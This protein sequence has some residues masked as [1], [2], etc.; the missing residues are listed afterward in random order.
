MTTNKA[1]PTILYED[2]HILVAVKPA[3]VLSQE[4]SSHAPDMLTILKAYLCEKYQKPGAAY[5]GL[6]HRLDRPVSGVMVFAKTSKA[7]SRLSLQMRQKEFTKKYR[8]IVEGVP[9]KAAGELHGYLYKDEKSNQVRIVKPQEADFAQAK[10]A[11]LYYNLLAEASW[12]EGGRSISLLEITLL[13]GRSHQIR[14]QLS[15]AGLP[16]LG[17]RK[18]GKVNRQYSGEICLESYYIGFIHPV[19]KEAMAFSLPLSEQLP[20]GLFLV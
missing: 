19:T 4:D 15:A 18:Y 9:S 20:W 7:A 16:I 14:V 17:D 11:R 1:V 12:S 6:I 13:T 10:E 2:N 3:G 8:A 5:L